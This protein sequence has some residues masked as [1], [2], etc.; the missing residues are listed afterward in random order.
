MNNVKPYTN[1]HLVV[2]IHFIHGGIRSYFTFHR[3]N[4]GAGVSLNIHSLIQPE[5]VWLVQPVLANYDM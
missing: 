5:F 4:F 3:C 1:I 2:Y